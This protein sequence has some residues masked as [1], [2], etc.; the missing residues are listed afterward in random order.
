MFE[1]LDLLARFCRMP[2]ACRTGGPCASASLCEDVGIADGDFVVIMMAKHKEPPAPPEPAAPAAP[3][4]PPVPA[5]TEATMQMLCDMGFP[6]D[7]V[8][9][10]AQR[11]NR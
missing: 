1:F 4:A 10:G 3:P 2:P 7:L 11:R 5:E 6:R 9:S 8:R